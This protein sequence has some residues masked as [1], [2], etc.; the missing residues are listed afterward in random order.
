MNHTEDRERVRDRERE[1]VVEKQQL[2]L[3]RMSCT[4]CSLL[5]ISAPSLSDTVKITICCQAEA[6][7]RL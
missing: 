6:V 5:I 2:T 7:E 4:S 1:G 3:K